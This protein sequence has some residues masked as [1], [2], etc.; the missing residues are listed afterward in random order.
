MTWLFNNPSDFA[1]EMVAGFV[2]ANAEIV[3]QVPG[4]VIR[5]TQSQPGTVAIV[6]GGGSGHYPAFAGWW[7]KDWRTARRW[8]TCSPRRPLS[9]FARWRKRPT[10]ARAYC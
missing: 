6:I 8:A 2:N 10:T 4:G 7:D 5:N 9:K 1:K 3:R